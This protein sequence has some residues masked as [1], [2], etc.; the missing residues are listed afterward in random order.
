MEGVLQMLLHSKVSGRDCRDCQKYV[1]D[2]ETGKKKILNAT[3]LPMLRN[4]SPPPCYKCKKIPDDAPFKSFRF[5]VDLSPK[6]RQA[7]HHYLECRAT[8]Q[9]PKDPIVRYN[10]SVLRMCFDSVL[11][12]TPELRN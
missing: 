6:N 2:E 8:G 5:A 9:F 10:A 12:L 7:L 1:Y 3:S 11:N 4:G